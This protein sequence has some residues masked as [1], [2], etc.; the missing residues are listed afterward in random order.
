MDIYNTKHV[1]MSGKKHSEESKRKTSLALMGK[2][3]PRYIDLTDKN[4]GRLVVIKEAGK[5]KYKKILWEC[6]CDPKFGG[7]GNIKIILGESLR[8]GCTQ[9]CGCIKKELMREKMRKMS[10]AHSGKNNNNYIDG[11]SKTHL[12]EIYRGMKKRCKSVGEYGIR[13]IFMC[14]LWRKDYVVFRNW[15]LENGYQ[16]NLT[17]DR[18]YGR[19]PYGPWN[20]QWLTFS[21]N[22]KKGKGKYY[23][24]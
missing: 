2:N 5:D 16:K 17:I 24:V 1:G 15:A 12:Y 18:I 9:S 14:R 20:C 23:G 19:G 11:R 21:E 10:K 6:F 22:L 8:S 13:G 4:F 7:C 3:N